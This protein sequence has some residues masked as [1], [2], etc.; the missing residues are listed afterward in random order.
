[1]AHLKSEKKKTKKKSMAKPS[2]KKKVSKPM[3]KRSGYQ[4]WPK[5]L[6]GQTQVTLSLPLPLYVRLNRRKMV[7]WICSTK[8]SSP[9][10]F[11]GVLVMLEFPLTR[12]GIERYLPGSQPFKFP[13][14]EV[15]PQ[16]PRALAFIRQGPFFAPSQY[17]VL[18]N[19]I[20]CLRIGTLLGLGAR[21]YKNP[22][23][24]Y[25]HIAL[26]SQFYESLF[27][28]VIHHRPSALAVGA[29]NLYCAELEQPPSPFYFLTLS[30]D[31]TPRFNGA[32]DLIHRN[33]PWGQGV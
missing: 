4:R 33:C 17:R 27:Q 19:A 18:L 25:K 29:H 21:G 24:F 10:K 32:V 8:S 5:V 3:S 20:L 12:D 14:M 15:D 26:R 9:R 30:A 7:W 11:Q 23:T 31:I 1:M 22:H 2:S 6:M 13:I 16:T 28:V